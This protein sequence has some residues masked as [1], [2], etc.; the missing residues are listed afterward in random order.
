M[1][2]LLPRPGFGAW[3]PA[4]EPPRRPRLDRAGFRGLAPA[5]AAHKLV[6]A[7]RDA[8]LGH[9]DVTLS[10]KESALRRVLEAF[11]DRG[12]DLATLQP[13]DVRLYHAYLRDMVQRGLLAEDTASN[14]SRNWNA[15]MR[16]VLGAREKPGDG[17]ILKGFRQHPKKTRLT[18]AELDAIRGALDR[19][20]F[21][22]MLTRLAFEAYLEVA[23]CAGP[24]I[25]SLVEGRV[26]VGDVDLAQGLVT[27]RHMKN[28]A[29]LPQGEDHVIVL[30]ARACTAVGRLVEYLEQ[31]PIWRGRDT[32][33]FCGPDGRPVTA[34]WLN[35]TL[36]DLAEAAGIHKP[37][38]THVL[39]KTAASLMASKNPQ[40]AQLQLGISEEVFRRHY[41]FPNLEERLAQRDLLPGGSAADVEPVA[42]R[43]P[44]PGLPGYQ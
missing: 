33:L 26:V 32:V 14:L 19:H 15:A 34:Q 28:A 11:W 9:R 21:R 3:Q 43:V 27:L 20:R 38:T 1:T 35:R 22:W 10:N 23:I 24:R 7:V 4:P 40:L 29:H 25:G 8:G 13:G 39:R 30:G 6:Q 12:R 2:K 44:K 5:V 16:M 18:Q 31:L 41:S 17:L 37:V 36:K 42:G